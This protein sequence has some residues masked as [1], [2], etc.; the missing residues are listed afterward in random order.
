MGNEGDRHVIDALALMLALR[1]PRMR[2]QPQGHELA[3]TTSSFG[4]AGS[5]SLSD[6]RDQIF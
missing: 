1:R 4:T 3:S 2:G 5:L 6:S